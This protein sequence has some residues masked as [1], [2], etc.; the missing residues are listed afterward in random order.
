MVNAAQSSIEQ[1]AK[2]LME[3]GGGVTTSIIPPSVI[4]SRLDQSNAMMAGEAL[5]GLTWVGYIQEIR[6]NSS[7]LGLL[8][9]LS[10][11]DLSFNEING[12]IVSEIGQLKNLVK[13]DLQQN[14]LTGHSLRL[15]SSKESGGIG[16]RTKQPHW[17]LPLSLGH[18][19]N[20]TS[21]S[22]S[23]N[24]INGS[25]PEGNRKHDEFDALVSQ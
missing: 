10:L 25:I 6:I 7:A 17:S 22:L 5:H 11:L 2:A 13:L 12:S 21:L 18:L 4:A 9:N 14:K 19:T 15:C 24:Q 3:V 23:S 8:A 20:L 1:E 16:P